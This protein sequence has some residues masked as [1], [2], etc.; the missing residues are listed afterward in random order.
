[1]NLRTLIIAIYVIN[2][3]NQDLLS[4]LILDNPRYAERLD[5]NS[6]NQNEV[7][8]LKDRSRETKT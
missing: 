1:M 7:K 4:N 8:W 6:H 2:I 5:H 3:A